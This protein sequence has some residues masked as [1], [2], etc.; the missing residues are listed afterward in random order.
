MSMYLGD[1]GDAVLTDDEGPTPTAGTPV[2][3]SQS[4]SPVDYSN[5]Y[6]NTQV[7]PTPSGA[8]P[9]GSATTTVGAVD[10][11]SG[12]PVAYPPPPPQ[13]G[14]GSAGNPPLVAAQPQSTTAGGF[15]TGLTSG[16]SSFFGPTKVVPKVAPNALPTW[17]LPVVLGVGG[18]AVVAVVLSTR[19]RPAMGRYKRR[20]RR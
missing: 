3:V 2:D 13:G 12:L 18:L 8:P 5:P 20:S 10:V 15:L 6:T 19:R 7:Y 11:N 4:Y 14:G 9:E 1:L 16:I 17:V